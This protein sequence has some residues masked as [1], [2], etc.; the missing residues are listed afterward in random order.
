MDWKDYFSFHDTVVE[1]V[2]FVLFFSKMAKQLSMEE[3]IK[4]YQYLRANQQPTTTT[5]TTTETNSKTHEM[6]NP[7][8]LS[9]IIFLIRK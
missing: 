3:L 1:I 2:E 8:F 7:E 6:E 4:K 5:T 9:K